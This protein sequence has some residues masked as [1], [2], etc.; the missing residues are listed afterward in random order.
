MIHDLDLADI[1]QKIYEM[2]EITRVYTKKPGEPPDFEEA[3]L[4]RKGRSTVRDL[5]NKIHRNMVS[6]FRTAQV[7]GSSMSDSITC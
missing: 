7:W 2:L 3:V 4:L 5:C 6:L 1:S